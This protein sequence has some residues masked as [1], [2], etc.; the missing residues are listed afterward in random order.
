M[1]SFFLPRFADGRPVGSVFFHGDKHFVCCVGVVPGAWNI[2]T[3]NDW[4][5]GC[6][7]LTSWSIRVIVIGWRSVGLALGGSA[8]TLGGFGGSGGLLDLGC[9]WNF[10]T[11][12]GLFFGGFAVRGSF[13]L[14]G[15]FI[16]WRSLLLCWSGELGSFSVAA[17]FLGGDIKFLVSGSLER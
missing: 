10:R 13:D 12:T 5:L 15:D 6:L 7:T 2:T 3:G 9:S 1:P 17:T 8:A 11:R 4:S 16:F 14:G